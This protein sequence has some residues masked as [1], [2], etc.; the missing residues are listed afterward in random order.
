MTS[1]SVRV[2]DRDRDRE[3]SIT[4]EVSDV[5]VD[6]GPKGSVKLD[7][8]AHSSEFQE[9]I[10]VIRVCGCHGCQERHALSRALLVCGK[11]QKIR[12]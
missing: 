6:V 3:R 12:T 4:A 1:Q 9:S 8:V 5:P 10:R 11:P 2:C 7:I